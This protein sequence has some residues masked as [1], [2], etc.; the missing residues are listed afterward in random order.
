M[1]TVQEILSCIKIQKK[2]KIQQSQIQSLEQILASQKE[3]REALL[4]QRASKEENPLPALDDH[5]ELMRFLTTKIGSGKWEE[6]NPL[7]LSV[8]SRNCL[9][10]ADLEYVY[11]LCEPKH[12]GWIINKK[13]RNFGNQSRDEIIKLFEKHQCN[14]EKIDEETLRLCE[15]IVTS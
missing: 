2:I 13:I 15:E 7:K 9:A 4:K 8:R 5:E 12:W 14:P 11:Q 10:M 1:R 3:K 6:P